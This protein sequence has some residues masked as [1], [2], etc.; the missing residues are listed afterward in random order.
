METQNRNKAVRWILV[1]IGLLAVPLVPFTIMTASGH[2]PFL[3]LAESVEATSAAAAVCFGLLSADV[4]LP[5]PSSFVAVISGKALGLLGG[6]VLNWI[7]ITLGHFIGFS[8]ARRLGRPIVIRFA[9]EAG[10]DRAEDLWSRGSVLGIILSRPVPV[11]AESLSMYA[12]LTKMDWKKY[13]VIVG[14]ANLP[15]SIIY[16]WAGA[17]LHDLASMNLIIAAGVGLPSIAYLILALSFRRG[18]P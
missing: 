15:H 8:L 7:A 5:V 11:L 6:S 14:V 13:L 18:Q 10:T 17:R 16:A 1:W 9:G 3:A 12:G 2:D 4:L